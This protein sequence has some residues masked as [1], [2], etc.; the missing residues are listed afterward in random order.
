MEDTPPRREYGPRP[1]GDYDPANLTTVDVWNRDGSSLD[2][3]NLMTSILEF[4]AI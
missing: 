4:A 1:E 3:S 2:D